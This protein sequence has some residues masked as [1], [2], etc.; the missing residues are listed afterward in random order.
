[1][2]RLSGRGRRG[3]STV[4]F[5]LVGP[6]FFFLLFSVVNGGIFLASRGAIQ[7]AAEIGAAEIAAE[8]NGPNTGSG[9]PTSCGTTVDQIAICEM[10]QAGLNYTVL[11]KVYAIT[12]QKMVPSTSGSGTLVASPSD[13]G[14][15]TQP[16]VDEYSPNGTVIKDPWT[17]RDVTEGNGGPDYAELTVIYTFTA[18]GN[19]VTFGKSPSGYPPTGGLTASVI[20]RL[21]PQIL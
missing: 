12:V 9:A 13:C 1:M 19:F 7:H 16:C 14:T 17:S 3:Q 18:V 4:E 15:G 20:F 6:L 8:G 11:T 2:R 10:D 21:E 5:A